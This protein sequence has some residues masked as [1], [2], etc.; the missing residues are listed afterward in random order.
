MVLEFHGCLVDLA[1]IRSRFGV[2]SKGT[3]LFQ[4]QTMLR[5][6]GMSARAYAAGVEKLRGLSFPCVLHWNSNHFVVLKGIKG[7]AYVVHDPALGRQVLEQS[8]FERHYSGVAL[9]S[10]PSGDFEPQDLR[11]RFRLG[12]LTVH[13]AGVKGLLGYVL[14][15]ALAVEILGILLPRQIQWAVDNFSA[16]L[17]ADSVI[18]MT[19]AFSAIVAAQAILSIAKNWAFARLGSE[20]NLDWYRKLL[21]HVLSLPAGFF[22]SRHVGDVAVKFQSLRTIQGALTKGAIDGILSG[23]FGVLALGA[24][25]LYDARLALVVLAVVLAYALA[26]SLLV[27]RVVELS[28]NELMWISATQG[29]LIETVNGVESIYSANQQGHRTRKNIATLARA[30]EYSLQSARTAGTITPVGQGIF[31]LSRVLIIAAAVLLSRKEAFTSGMLVACVTYADIF[32]AKTA[33]LLEKIFELKHLR[34][35]FEGISEYARTRPQDLGREHV[36]VSSIPA[37]ISL[38]DVGFRYSPSDPWVFRNLNIEIGGGEAVAVIGSSGVGK[39]TLA[40][41]I[42]GLI[43][44]TEGQILVGGIPLAEVGITNFRKIC[45]T[46]L[47]DDCLFSGSVS[48]NICWFAEDCDEEAVHWA[49]KLAAIHDDIVRMPMKYLTGISGRGGGLSGGQRQRI[50]LARALYKRPRVLLL[51]EATSHLDVHNE[52]SINSALS[53]LEMTRIVFAHRQETIRSADRVIDLLDAQ[54][55]LREAISA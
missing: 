39:S 51:D 10:E 54:A 40:K 18:V 32:Y 37:S 34:G 9:V 30:L 8:E 53:G 29:D 55:P 17:S 19:V 20:L 6:F 43:E 38:R 21:A 52:R 44:P 2:S 23:L 41:L 28:R 33:V 42:L 12:E 49:A 36:D 25:L 14:F 3:S 47:Q 16:S 31:S 24:I 11:Q 5:H 13:L 15:L 45:A 1:S 50:V 35:H 48:E 22:S 4:I 27:G 46:V 26:R 7:N